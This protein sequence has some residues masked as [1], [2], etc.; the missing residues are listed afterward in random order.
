MAN[1]T[2]D[3]I[4]K[5]ARARRYVALCQA[6]ASDLEALLFELP[7][8][9]RLISAKNELEDA[10][11]KEAEVHQLAKDYFENTHKPHPAVRIMNCI[12]IDYDLDEMKKWAIE[13]NQKDMLELN[14]TAA[15]KAAVEIVLGFV[16][17]SR[18]D[19]AFIDDDLNEYI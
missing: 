11:A 13:H 19:Q 15:N 18:E 9:Q 6:N 7:E 10:K 4:K 14:K 12:I 8:Y 5:L 3:L 17:I 2:V 16:E 1:E